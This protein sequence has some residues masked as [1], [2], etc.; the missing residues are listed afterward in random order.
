MSKPFIP[1]QKH[2]IILFDGVCNFCNGW[3]KF[4]I[5]RDRKA[6]FRFS[7]YQSEVA[8]RLF[9]AHHID[10]AGVDSIILMENGHCYTEST[11]VLHIL[12]KMDGIWP[13]LYVLI[14]IPRPLRDG[15]YRWFAKNRYR[16][17]GKQSAC[18]IPTPEIRERFL[19]LPGKDE[20]SHETQ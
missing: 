12:R 8:K 19:D 18:M 13:G 17:F 14:W 4:V 1:T 11:A 6:Q 16:F 2:S 5:R 7:S 9:Q 20:A 3:V 15:V 10:P